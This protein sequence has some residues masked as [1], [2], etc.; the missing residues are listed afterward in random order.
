MGVRKLRAGLVTLG[1]LAAS[2][3]IV[4]VGTA[5]YPSSTLVLLGALAVVGVAG[6]VYVAARRP[7]W[8]VPPELRRL[9]RA[10]RLLMIRRCGRGEGL[11]DPQLAGIA[12]RYA[13][14]IRRDCLGS[15]GI[16]AMFGGRSA[17]VAAQS[18]SLRPHWDVLVALAVAAYC[19]M[20]ARRFGRAE[21]ANEEARRGSPAV[22]GAGVE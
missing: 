7:A 12:V 21:A 3:V 19:L 11:S 18:Q 13:H 22:A 5:A 6:G 16:A 2:A 4:A 9:D 10:D 8:S 15:A 1:V 17:Y 14:R 20:R